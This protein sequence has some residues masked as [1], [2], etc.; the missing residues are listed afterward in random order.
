MLKKVGGSKGVGVAFL[1][2]PFGTHNAA[3]RFRQHQEAARNVLQ[4]L[5]PPSNRAIRSRATSHEL[6]QAR[7][8]LRI[9]AI[10][11]LFW[12]VN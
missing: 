4:S 10:F 1:E 8:A 9:L 2:Q 7:N 6:L 11:S 5:L 12:T 3:A